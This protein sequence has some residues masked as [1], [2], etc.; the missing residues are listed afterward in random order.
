MFYR[1]WTNFGI[2]LNKNFFWFDITKYT[3][4]YMHLINY[5]LI[6]A[7]IHLIIVN[8]DY[9]TNKSKLLKYYKY[10]ASIIN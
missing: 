2:V 3:L 1:Y 10:C 4:V 6:Q 8:L 9:R 7:N 5:H